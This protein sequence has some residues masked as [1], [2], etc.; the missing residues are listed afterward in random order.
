MAALLAGCEDPTGPGDGEIT[1]PQT[2]TYTSTSESG[3]SYSLKIIENTVTSKAAYGARAGDV[4]ELTVTPPGSISRGTVSNVSAGG[5]LQLKPLNAVAVTETFRVTVSPAANGTAGGMT[6][7]RGTIIYTDD[8]KEVLEEISLVSDSV[9]TGSDTAYYTVSGVITGGDTNNGVIAG[10]TVTLQQGGNIIANVKTIANGSYTMSG[11]AAGAYSIGVVAEGYTYGSIESFAVNADVT[12]NLTLQE[13]TGS[14]TFTISGTIT[15]SDTNAGISE[16]SV[17]LN[18]VGSGGDTTL[19]GNNGAYSFSDVA[20][21]IYAIYVRADGYDDGVIKAVTVTNANLSSKNLALQKTTTGG[22]LYTVSGVI[23]GSDTNG[24]GI[25]GVPVE[26]NP[27]GTSGSVKTSTDD[28]GAYYFSGVAPGTYNIYVSVP[29]YETA[30]INGVAVTNADVRN[31]IITLQKTTTYTVSGLITGSDTN[32]AGISGASVELNLD[33]TSGSVKTSTDNN[34]AYYFSG[35]APG[36]YNIYVSVQG[37]VTT[38]IRDVVVTNA[39][40]I[41][42]ITL[43]KTPTGGGGAQ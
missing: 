3:V 4:Y 17:T 33:G 23:T 6:A 15:G 18:R 29:G 31:S 37:Y 25:P 16:A 42:S 34:G 14:A 43:Q 27:A 35:V 39:D 40:V 7:I 28:N 36:T 11:V 41:E 12:K 26:L 22:G 10:A 24:E 2:I 13:T 19:T 21:G 1:N 30:T 20:P 9:D 32:N 8:V 5:E 38:N